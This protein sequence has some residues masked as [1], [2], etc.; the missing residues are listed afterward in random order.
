MSSSKLINTFF[1]YLVSGGTATSVHFS[2]LIA[3]MEYA[4]QINATIATTAAFFVAVL[5][6]YN[7]QY[8]WTFKVTGSHKRFF[9]RYICVT[10]VTMALNAS[11]FWYYYE[12]VHLS[13][14]FSQFFATGLVF[15]VNFLI[16]NFFTFKM[17]T[18]ES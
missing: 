17:P 4:P 13:Y 3:F 11:V 18:N 7:I 10:F 6:N 5:V 2:V 9:I 16:N 8:H 14:L 1:R 12:W 15:M